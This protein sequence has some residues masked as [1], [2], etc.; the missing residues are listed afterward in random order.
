MYGY[1]RIMPTII[2]QIPNA[3]SLSRIPASLGFVLLYSTSDKTQFWISIFIVCFALVTDLF[4]GYL[5][6]KWCVTSVTGYFLDGIGDKA[7]TVAVLLVISREHPTLLFLAWLLIVREIFLYALR[8]LDNKRDA[9]LNSLRLFSLMQAFFIRVFFLGF[10]IEG[11]LLVHGKTVFWGLS[12]YILAGYLSV[13]FGYM[14]L[15]RLSKQIA[16]REILR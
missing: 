2:D 1:L 7:F 8:A 11:A 4:D 13:I 14:T 6:R 16:T 15:I 5:A 12:T 9:N 3:L 10:F